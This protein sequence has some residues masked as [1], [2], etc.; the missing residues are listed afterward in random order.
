MGFNVFDDNDN[1]N[2]NDN[3]SVKMS[4]SNNVMFIKTNEYIE[5]YKHQFCG[6]EIEDSGNETFY[7]VFI[8]E[9]NKKWYY[10][11]CDDDDD[12]YN[13]ICNTFQMQNNIKGATKFYYNDENTKIMWA[14]ENNYG[15]N[16]NKYYLTFDQEY[17]L[18][19]LL[20]CENDND[21]FNY[22]CLTES[23]NNQYVL[24]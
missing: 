16:E 2:D 11:D 20:F 3:D 18:P 24:K 6:W 5:E 19:C 13:S 7:I 14:V 9:Q 15:I 10:N 12:Y 22:V 23:I 8:T 1:D 17:E 21:K 4:A